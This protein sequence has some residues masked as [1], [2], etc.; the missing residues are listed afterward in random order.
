MP[1]IL[2]GEFI[3]VPLSTNTMPPFEYEIIGRITKP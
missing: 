3:A 2:Y 1:V